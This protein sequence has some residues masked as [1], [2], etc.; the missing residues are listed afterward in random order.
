MEKRSNKERE[1][2]LEK[3]FDRINSTLVLISDSRLFLGGV[4]LDNLIY[5]R[6]PGEEEMCRAILRGQVGGPWNEGMAIADDPDG[7]TLC[8]TLNNGLETLLQ[9]EI[10]AKQVRGKYVPISREG[11]S[12]FAV[13][14]LKSVRFEE[15][16]KIIVI[17]VFNI[18]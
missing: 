8:S 11:K 1:G 6:N 5:W 15:W 18:V 12:L 4:K 10:R 7:W 3:S 13:L 17:S 16:G 9:P 14:K 2:Y